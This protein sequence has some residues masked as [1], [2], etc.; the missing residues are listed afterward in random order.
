MRKIT[1]L[2][3]FA[4]LALGVSFTACNNDDVPN[5]P[6]GED[7]DTHMSVSLRLSTKSSRLTEDDYNAV[8]KWAG[9]DE[10]TNLIVYLVDGSTVTHK[11]FE[12]GTGKPY[13]VVDDS[14]VKRIAPKTNDAA[15]RTTAGKKDVYVLVNATAKIETHLNHASVA[16]FERAYN[17]VALGLLDGVTDKTVSAASFL[18]VGDDE[19]D[20]ITMT[21]VSKASLTVTAGVSASESVG[22]GGDYGKDVVNRVTVQVERALARVMVTIEGADDGTFNVPSNDPQNPGTVGV[23][24]DITWVV[25]QGE[26]KIFVQRQAEWVTPEYSWIPTNN[27]D[28]WAQSNSGADNTYD[29]SGL[30]ENQG[31]GFGGTVVPALTGY[32]ALADG[33]SK[34]DVLASI[35]LDA[36]AL[37][38]KFILPTTHEYDA[39]GKFYKKG[40][41]AYVLVRAKF[42]PADD[43]WG[44]TGT[45]AADGTFYIGVDGRFYTTAQAAYNET[46]DVT[47]AKYPEGKVLYYAW[48]NP[49]KIPDWYNSPVL[50]NNI[51]HIHIS[52][53]RNIGTNW[54][55]LFPELPDHNPKIPNPNYDP[56]EPEGPSNPKE[57]DNPNYNPEDRDNPD[58]KP[59]PETV[60]DPDD[61]SKEIPTEEPDNP[62]DPEDPLTKEET[63]M[64]VDVEVLQWNVHSYKVDLGI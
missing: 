4:V 47:I 43:A 31:T 39:A 5:T 10:I 22:N 26:S 30:Y 20:I 58:P 33:N 41:T 12:V 42:T 48:V 29:Y 17:E 32:K 59:T 57:I 8:G 37:N 46:K 35:G 56:N 40:N 38:G 62:I 2:L 60:T 13:Q 63:W 28:Y 21:N 6:Q 11:K 45:Q 14:G 1:K 27:H 15:I 24:S 23:L 54:N 36:N 55:P 50:R 19:K 53:F 7:G 25:A 9:Q 16:A 61:P 51:Y 3:M 52:G 34:E 18:S 44:D 49:D 64:S